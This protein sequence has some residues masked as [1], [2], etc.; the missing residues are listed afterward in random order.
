MRFLRIDESPLGVIVRPVDPMAGID[1]SR[2]R[3]W[4]YAI[5]EGATAPET[6]RQTDRETTINTLE[7]G[8]GTFPCSLAEGASWPQGEWNL[9]GARDSGGA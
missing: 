1:V 5:A 4:L 6:L 8:D 2:G 7:R 3:E 9:S